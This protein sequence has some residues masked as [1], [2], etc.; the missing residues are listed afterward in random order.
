MTR[1]SARHRRA[2][3][4]VSAALVALALAACSSSGS[5]PSSTSGGLTQVTVTVFPGTISSIPVYIADAMGYFK[6]HGLAVKYV[7]V[8]SSGSAFDTMAAGDTDF[9]IADLFG[10]ESA[11]NAG[12]D[13]V[14][15]SGETSHYFGQL[16]CQP[17]LNVAASYPQSMQS[18]VGKTIGITSPTSPT[19]NY[20]KYSLISAGID[21]SKVKFVQLNSIQTLT[22]AFDAK[23]IDCLSEYQ[24]MQEQ[25]KDASVVVN[26]QAGEGPAAIKEPI[27]GQGIATTSQFA[28]A[29]PALIKD[30]ALAMQQ[31]AQFSSNPAN[32]DT[33]AQKTLK[34]YQGLSEA[35]LAGIVKNISGIFDYHVTEQEWAN[36]KQMYTAD[37]GQPYKDSYEDLVPATVRPIISGS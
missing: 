37:T 13:A 36:T 18:V 31:S 30:F 4:L 17:G 19:E 16:V 27:L 32:A 26:W 2:F 8:G 21:P 7:G 35:E 5:T 25:I 34:W 9:I 15:I 20:V 1:L 12:S 14:L 6:A 23:R 33:I 10:T 29:H 22:A 28:S 3:A 24:P 11:R